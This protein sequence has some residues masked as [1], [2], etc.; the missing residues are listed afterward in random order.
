MESTPLLIHH[1]LAKTGGTSLWRVM[2]A[3][4]GAGELMNLDAQPGTA[5][6]RQPSRRGRA[7]RSAAPAKLEWQVKGDPGTWFRDYWESLTPAQRDRIRCIGSHT[8]QHLIPVV[9]DRPVRAVCMLRDPVGRIISLYLFMQWRVDRLGVGGPARRTIEEMR[10]REWTLKDVYRELGG[11]G[12]PPNGLD[13]LFW[14]FFN[15]QAREVLAPE[16]DRLAL[17]FDPAAR[18]L[19][20]Y[21][22]RA[23][24]ALSETYLVGTQDRFSQSVRMFAD[25]FGWR[26]SFVPEMRVNPQTSRR[27]EFDEETRSLIRAHNQI[28]ADLHGRYSERLATMP[29]TRRLPETAWRIRER[30]RRG[31]RRL[32]WGLGASA[33]SARRPAKP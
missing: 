11:P 27:D 17:P 13:E 21:R 9:D 7:E 26:R 10:K 33:A 8:A 6:G 20:D 16:V 23:R 30:A 32:G 2:E 15:G 29:G 18:E 14:P 24:R 3:N 22:D 5:A 25:A 31:R 4:Y 28:D 19:G 1:H 12:S